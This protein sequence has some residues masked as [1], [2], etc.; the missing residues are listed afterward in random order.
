MIEI[1]S[2]LTHRLTK[3][4]DVQ[5]ANEAGWSIK[6]EALVDSFDHMI[7]ESAVNCFGEGIT[8]IVGLFHLQRHPGEDQSG[9]GEVKIW[10]RASAN[11]TSSI[12]VHFLSLHYI[13]A[14]IR[15]SALYHHGETSKNTCSLQNAEII[16]QSK[17]HLF[18]PSFIIISDAQGCGKMFPEHYLTW[19]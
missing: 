14:L 7:K 16:Y 6:G 13:F 2:V 15:Q 18:P 4:S 9:T 5:H 10:V 11:A 12:H 3:A 19:Q 8:G 1:N 17:F